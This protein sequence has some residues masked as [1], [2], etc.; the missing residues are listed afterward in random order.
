MLL[1]IFGDISNYYTVKYASQIAIISTLNRGRLFESRYKLN[2]K[3][4]SQELENS[5]QEFLSGL[6]EVLFFK[7]LK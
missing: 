2:P 4:T 6:I 7:V 3:Q 1:L 5:F